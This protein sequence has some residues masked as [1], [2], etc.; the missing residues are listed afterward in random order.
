MHTVHR[1]EM[2]D[3]SEANYL[4]VESY[5]VVLDQQ[6]IPALLGSQLPSQGL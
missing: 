5:C 4:V 3:D 6:R 2:L 1:F